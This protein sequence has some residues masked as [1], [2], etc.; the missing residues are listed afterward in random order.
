M[1]P[2][3]NKHSKTHIN[4]KKLKKFLKDFL[5]FLILSAK[6]VSDITSNKF[7]LKDSLVIG[8]FSR[9]DEVRGQ[10]RLLVVQI[11]NINLIFD[12]KISDVFF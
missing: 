1:Y 6:Y 8:V 2:R 12:K 9:N 11:Q 3:P 10:R 5:T 7:F 4:R